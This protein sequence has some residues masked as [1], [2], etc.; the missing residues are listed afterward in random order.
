M[1]RCLASASAA[2][3]EAAGASGPVATAAV[4]LATHEYQAPAAPAIART[5]RAANT[6]SETAR[7]F[8]AVD[9]LGAA[10]VGSVGA[11]TSTEYARTGR[12]MF[13]NCFS[14]RSTKL[15]STLPRT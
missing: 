8:V 15:A 12:A 3:V 7:L 14:P 6:R 13:F 2:A 4:R 1:E 5:P 11:S 10:G 9:L